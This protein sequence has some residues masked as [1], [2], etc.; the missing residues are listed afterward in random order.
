MFKK[1]FDCFGCASEFGVRAGMA[2]GLENA[3]K[4]VNNA[5]ARDDDSTTAARG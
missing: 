1:P 5:S 2:D 4:D 3:R